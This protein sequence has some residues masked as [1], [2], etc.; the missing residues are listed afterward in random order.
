MK[1]SIFQKGFSGSCVV[2]SPLGAPGEK[3]RETQMDLH[4]LI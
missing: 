4:D 3:K 2:W 1:W